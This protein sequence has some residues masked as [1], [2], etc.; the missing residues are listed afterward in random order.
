MKIKK[1][2]EQLKSEQ[3]SIRESAIASLLTKS[4]DEVMP[5]IGELLAED[6]NSVT[7][8][9]ALDIARSFDGTLSI[10][11]LNRDNWFENLA[12][13]SDNF[14]EVVRILGPRFLAYSIILGVQIT[15]LIQGNRGTSG[16]VV[17]FVFGDLKDEQVLPL[18]SFRTQVTA[19]LLGALDE[20]L[21]TV[22]FPLSIENIEQ[23]ISSVVLLVA[24]LLGISLKRVVAFKKNDKVELL[25]GVVDS[26]GYKFFYINTLKAYIR[27]ALNEDIAMARQR[28]QLD[29][30]VIAKAQRA[31]DK[32][33]FDEVIL[34]L[35]T[36]PG[37][38]T[39]MLKTPEFSN[40]SDSQIQKIAI[41]LNI[42][43]HSF[44]EKNDLRWAEEL[45]RLGIQYSK[46]SSHCAE[47]YLAMGKLLNKSSRN[48]EAIGHLK[49]AYNLLENNDVVLPELGH[50]LLETNKNICA[51]LVLKKA[52]DC[53]GKITSELQ[54]DYDAS[55]QIIEKASLLWPK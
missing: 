50:A 29:L 15:K 34:L 52:Y 8:S 19:A 25:T 23:A 26:E 38:L 14:E 35:E 3:K 22:T 44:A 11:P 12:N 43:G 9:A 48:G 2:V 37:L 18:G 41:G 46:D 27:K 36:W 45:Y 10:A 51:R 20:D 7:Q 30:A 33:D 47:L 21:N 4:A 32:R 17:H 42:L 13:G 40:L 5:H 39:T 31:Y 16:T 54:A 53:S 49:R 6:D 55:Q 24:P 1:L 28:F